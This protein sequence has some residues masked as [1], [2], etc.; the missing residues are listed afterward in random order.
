MIRILK[1]YYRE[2]DDMKI[3]YLFMVYGAEGYGIY[4]ALREMIHVANG[5][6]VKMDD[7]FYSKFCKFKV[8]KERLSLIIN[9][10]A[11][12]AEIFSLHG[13]V[14]TLFGEIPIVKE[15]RR[16]DLFFWLNV[17]KNIFKR[18]NYKCTYCGVYAEKLECDHIIP[19]SKGGSNDMDNLTTACRTCNRQ[20][21][22]KSVAE[23]IIYKQK[24]S[25]NGTTK[26]I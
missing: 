8:D 14:L 1:H 4:W 5:E 21:K 22:D 9:D 15:G 7:E 10:L 16:K 26:K 12:V 23:F 18:D 11:N 19:V 3:K 17:R 6:G 25:T 13:D 20:K 2:R 24:I